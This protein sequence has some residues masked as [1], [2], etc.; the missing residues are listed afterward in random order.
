MGGI[1]DAIE[2][3]THILSTSEEIE[4]HMGKGTFFVSQS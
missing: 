2:S 1:S 4:V 3:Y